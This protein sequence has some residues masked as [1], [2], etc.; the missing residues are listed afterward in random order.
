MVTGWSGDFKFCWAPSGTAIY[1]ERTFRGARN[2]W[3]MAIDPRTLQ[4]IA[5][6]RL[7]TGPGFDSEPSLSPDGSKAA[8]TG[9]SK[10]VRGWMFPFDA[11][12]GRITG[13]G[14]VVT[15]P[16]IDAWRTNLSPNGKKLVFGGNRS[17]KWELWETSILDQREAL[18]VADDSYERA[19]PQWSPDGARIAYRRSKPL[20]GEHQLMIWS[21]PSQKEEPVTEASTVSKTPQDWSPDGKSL[22]VSVGDSTTHKAEVWLVPTNSTSPDAQPARKIISD[23]NHS[24][25]EEHFSPN[26]RWI[27][28]EASR[29]QSRS[30]ESTLYVMAADGGAWIHIT[31]GKYW[32][33]KPRWSPDGKTI[34]F[35]SSRGGFFNVWGIHF[36]PTKGEIVG[37]PFAV[38]AFN[39]PS[40][41]I[42]RHM[43]RVELSLTQDR[44]VLSVAQ[45]SGNIWM[46]NNVNR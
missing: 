43:G 42:P 44:L 20:S 28:F 25:W 46:L 4:A 12:R 22:L 32:D 21:S 2:I 31:D 15:S 1:F 17:G 37:D 36:D 24:L 38:S 33:D 27:V 35:L 40:L 7:T 34:Y 9:E 14:Q 13:P 16:G 30:W 5:L 3:R 11:T 6:E 41:M 19:F 29:N 26:G 10:H 18:V 8:F 39:S 45:V 23:P